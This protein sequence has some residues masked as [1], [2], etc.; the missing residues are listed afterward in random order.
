[1]LMARRVRAAAQTA[2]MVKALRGA[3]DRLLQEKVGAVAARGRAAAAH[4]RN[5]RPSHGFAV[6]EP[7]RT[8]LVWRTLGVRAVAA[9]ANAQLGALRHGSTAGQ[10]VLRPRSH[11]SYFSLHF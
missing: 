3:L 1:M 4:A 7:C 6:H 2:V 8:A 11:V 5:S 10:Q 9:C